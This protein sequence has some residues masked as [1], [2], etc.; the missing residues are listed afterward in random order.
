MLDEIQYSR[1]DYAFARFLVQCSALSTEHG[2][3]FE[4]IVLKLSYAQTQGNSCI[5][6]N[7]EEQS[8]LLT[9]GVADDSGSKPLVLENKKLYLQ[10][11]WRYECQIVS[12]IN[13]VISTKHLNP[14][15]S[16]K[17]KQYFSAS[18]E[19]DWQKQAAEAAIQFPFTI[20][21]GGPGTGKTTTVIKILALLQELSSKP[22]NIAF[23]RT[24]WQSSNE[25]ARIK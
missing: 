25:V 21:T 4:S 18:N 8:I 23:G 6:V 19:I 24:D 3:Q 2:K 14:V 9:S 12:K 15:A 13:A 16:E 22:L 10:R 11:Y 7:N 5:S 20:I 1:L 17:I